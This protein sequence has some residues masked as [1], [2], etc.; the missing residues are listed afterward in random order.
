MRRA[1]KIRFRLDAA[2]AAANVSDPVKLRSDRLPPVHVRLTAIGAA[3]LIVFLN[4]LAASPQLHAWVHGENAAQA[5][6]LGAN[7]G[8]HQGRDDGCAVAVFAAGILA[9]LFALF[10][11]RRV[12]GL[13]R[14]VRRAPDVPLP[15]PARNRL[16]PLCG[17]PAMAV[18]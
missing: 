18:G 2:H 3:L 6:P 15:A 10:V 14:V 11:A 12:G 5:L 17:P 13:A 8:P 1:P 4:L 9:G 7:H 16:P